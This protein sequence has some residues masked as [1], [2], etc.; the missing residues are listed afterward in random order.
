MQ[1]RPPVSA[2][3]VL[4]CCTKSVGEI[5]PERTATMNLIRSVSWPSAA[6]S[7]S[8]SG[9]AKENAVSSDSNPHSSACLQNRTS[10]PRSG[11]PESAARALA[12]R[13]L[14]PAD[15]MLQWKRSG[16][17]ALSDAVEK[18]LAE[19][20]RAPVAVAREAQHHEH[21]LAQ[22][23]LQ[24]HVARA[25]VVRRGERL[26]EAF[27]VALEV[28]VGGDGAPVAAV[29]A[30]DVDVQHAAVIAH[31]DAHDPARPRVRVRPS[32]GEHRQ[33]GTRLGA[34]RQRLRGNGHVPPPSRAKNSR[35]TRL[36]SSLNVTSTISSRLSV[37]CT[38]AASNTARK[39]AASL[40]AGAAA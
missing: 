26:L 10:A 19:V 21:A 9:R 18:L 24:R 15:D 11:V 35:V 28:D 12:R 31:G 37:A 23:A 32:P 16:V 13:S 7:V 6:A 25:E 14:S 20:I 36:G 40:S 5:V 30:G 33:V 34:P 29:G 39:P 1:T 27:V 2:A 17:M 4:T 38:S 22:E 8:G 3:T